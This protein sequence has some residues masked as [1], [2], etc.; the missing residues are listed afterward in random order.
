MLRAASHRRWA[1]RCRTCRRVAAPA[2]AA[3][4]SIVIG[5]DGKTAAAFSYADA[6]RERVF[7]PLP[8]VDQ[9]RDGVADRTA[10][11]HHPPEGVQEGLKVAG[12]HRPE[13]VLHDARARQ[14]GRS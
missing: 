11:E 9:D 14:R 13:P 3:D 2:R 10:I 4:P 1:R 7:I 6:V 5:P 12:D 8:G